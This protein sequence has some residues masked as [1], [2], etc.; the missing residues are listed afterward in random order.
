MPAGADFQVPTSYMVVKVN[1]TGCCGAAWGQMQHPSHTYLLHF[2][3]VMQAVDGGQLLQ[4][5]PYP[6]L[7]PAVAFVSHHLVFFLL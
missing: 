4:S 7:H 1:G 2:M 5:D 3:G 6:R